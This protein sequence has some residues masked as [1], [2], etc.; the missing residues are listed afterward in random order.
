M[1]K[2]SDP[3]VSMYDDTSFSAAPRGILRISATPWM[4]HH[5]VFW[6]VE[7]SKKR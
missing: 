4:E 3:R 7:R 2:W 5:V 6:T 1:L